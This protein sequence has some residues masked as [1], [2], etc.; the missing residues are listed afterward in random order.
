MVRIEDTTL[1]PVTSDADW[2]AKGWADEAE[3]LTAAPRLGAMI[4]VRLDPDTAHAVRQA[5]RIEGIT[6]SEFV[7]RAAVRAAAA[8]EQEPLELVAAGGVVPL[9]SWRGS[10]AKVLPLPPPTK[11]TAVEV[12]SDGR[13]L[14][15]AS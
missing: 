1:T 4:S 5:A 12:R 13:S 10:H 14:L 3:P 15:A 8:V 6:R 2:Q 11:S 7:R 9:I